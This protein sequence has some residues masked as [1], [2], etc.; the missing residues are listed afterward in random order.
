[1]LKYLVKRL[2]PENYV[3]QIKTTAS[4]LPV[5]IGFF[6]CQLQKNRW[7]EFYINQNVHFLPKLELISECLV[8]AKDCSNQII[9]LKDTL[10]LR[11][12]NNEILRKHLKNFMV[13]V[14]SQ[15]LTKEMVV[16][17]VG[18]NTG[19][20]SYHWSNYCKQVHA[21]E[22]VLPVYFQLH[23]VSVARNN[24][25]TY[26]VALGKNVTS[27][28]KFYIDGAR[29]SNSGL[30]DGLKGKVKSQGFVKVKQS[31]LDS[32]DLEKVDFIKIDTEGN[33]L[34]VICGAESTIR[35]FRPLCMVECYPKFA[36]FNLELIH[37]FFDSIKYICMYNI[38][39]YGLT[40]I[41]TEAD[42]LKIT[43]SEKMLIIHDGDFLFIPEEKVSYFGNHS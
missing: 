16:V 4:H 39:E 7:L 22:A 27:D 42:F 35:K 9:F 11:V 6:C 23:R 13:G 19:M 37:R 28:T 10:S 30:S 14:V 3:L 24:I 17:D 5:N 26:N 12:F 21:F 25:E 31:T 38:P 43:H 33:E 2:F 18:A 40:K 36:N 41:P 15:Y 29:L 1:M 34:D 8:P 32:Y 20:Y